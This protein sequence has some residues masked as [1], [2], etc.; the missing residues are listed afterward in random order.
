[1]KKRHMPQ[2]MS[3]RMIA[4]MAQSIY[5]QEILL[6]EVGATEH[7]IQERPAVHHYITG[8]PIHNH[9]HL[10]VQVVALV[11]VQAPIPTMFI[12][13]IMDIRFL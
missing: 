10:A 12:D 7:T 9:Y 3:T 5:T 4:T 2:R 13:V 6:S 11:P 1:M 8:K